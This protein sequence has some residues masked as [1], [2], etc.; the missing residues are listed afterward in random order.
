MKKHY[1]LFIIAIVVVAIICVYGFQFNGRSQDK[2][3]KQEMTP[4]IDVNIKTEP[5]LKLPGTF[6]LLVTIDSQITVSDVVFQLEMPDGFRLLDGTENWQGKLE[7]GVRKEFHF[8]IYSSVATFDE[9]K[10]IVK[11]KDLSKYWDTI[12]FRDLD[13]NNNNSADEKLIPIAEAESSSFFNLLLKKILN[14]LDIFTA[15]H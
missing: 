4:Q 15:K 1:L 12:S 13:K 11:L 9:I 2:N 7:K 14:L 8:N 5:P 3:N 6:S 10:A